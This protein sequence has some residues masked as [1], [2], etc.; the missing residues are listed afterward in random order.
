M[1]LALL[2][3]SAVTTLERASRALLPWIALVQTEQILV[4]RARSAFLV[5][6]W[7]PNLPLNGSSIRVAFSNLG[8]LQDRYREVTAAGNSGQPNL[9][10]PLA[11]LAGEF[12]GIVLSPT[13]MILMAHEASRA[14]FGK[15][16]GGVVN[17]VFALVVG[18]L[19]AVLWPFGLA[20]YG[21]ASLFRRG[22]DSATTPPSGPSWTVRGLYDLLGAVARAL[23]AASGFIDLLLGPRE[24]VRNPLLRLVLELFDGLAGLFAQ[25]MGALALLVTRFLPLLP[26]MVQQGLML[27]ELAREVFA[28]VSE[29]LDGAKASLMSFVASADNSPFSIVKRVFSTIRGAL[30]LFMRKITPITNGATDTFTNA[31]RRA[32]TLSSAWADTAK[33]QLETGLKSHPTAMVIEAAIARMAVISGAIPASV[34]APTT[35]PAPGGPPSALRRVATAIGVYAIETIVGPTALT[36]PTLPDLPD[37]AA[38]L[39]RIAFTPGSPAMTATLSGVGSELTAQ[40]DIVRRAAAS[41]RARGELLRRRPESI[42]SGER[43]ALDAGP[44]VDTVLDAVLNEHQRFRSLFEGVLGR[45]APPEIRGAVMSLGDVFRAI[46]VPDFPVRDLPDNGRLRLVVH[47]LKVRA[48]DRDEIIVRT[49]TTHLT[50][51]LEAQLYVALAGP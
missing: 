6:W 22:G 4:E 29:A 42:F 50:E 45:V 33:T 16:L 34:A 2:L 3:Q 43:R 39:A 21:I 48:C 44:S 15:A 32:S 51:R 37:T 10:E 30:P 25:L 27:K 28:L 20:G 35:P 41:L 18:P 46:A 13:G 24:N 31:G 26:S 40:T 5:H 36:P 23:S 11:G 7:G 38:L 47:K 9:T 17:V 1:P 14:L 49:F 12:A 19:A 8:A